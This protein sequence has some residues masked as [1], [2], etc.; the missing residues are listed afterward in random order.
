MGSHFYL[1]RKARQGESERE[2][3]RERSVANQ[4]YEDIER[5]LDRHDQSIDRYVKIEQAWEAVYGNEKPGRGME[6]PGTV[7]LA[8]PSVKPSDV[9]DPKASGRGSEMLLS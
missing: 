6:L 8:R 2:E 4:R 7:W 5:R 3:E 1:A 9:L